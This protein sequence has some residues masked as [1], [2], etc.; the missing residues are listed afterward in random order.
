MIIQGPK[1]TRKD[2]LFRVA[3]AF[4]IAHKDQTDAL[5]IDYDDWTLDGACLREEMKRELEEIGEA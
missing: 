4:L 5:V 1:E 3:T 2:F